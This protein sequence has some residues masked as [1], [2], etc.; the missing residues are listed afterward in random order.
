MKKLDAESPETKS[1]DIGAGNVETLRALF[2]DSFTEGGID[3]DV[4]KGLLGAAVDER[5]ERYGLSWHG[6]ERVN[7]FDPTFCLI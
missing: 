3:F 6:T 2:P 1:A 5:D 7:D 4:L